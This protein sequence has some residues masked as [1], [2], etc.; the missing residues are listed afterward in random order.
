MSN[1]KFQNQKKIE[2][3]FEFEIEKFKNIFKKVSVMTTPINFWSMQWS[4]WC[5]KFHL[6]IFKKVFLLA[7]S[8]TTLWSSLKAKKTKMRNVKLQHKW[9][10]NKERG[11]VNFFVTKVAL[12]KVPS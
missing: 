1:F 3:E 11:C 4:N 2:F 7:K 6:A 12:T 8:G 5:P 10:H 9:G